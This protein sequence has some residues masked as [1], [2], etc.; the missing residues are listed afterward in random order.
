MNEALYK[1]R[2]YLPTPT[3]T[4]RRVYEPTLTT[5]NKI[6]QG[7]RQ[8]A[9]VS[10]KGSLLQSLTAP[11]VRGPLLSNNEMAQLRL[12][13]LHQLIKI[14]DSNNIIKIKT[15]TKITDLTGR[16]WWLTL[17]TNSLTLQK[18]TEKHRYYQLKKQYPR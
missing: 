1:K 7:N 6:I 3:A 18:A 16:K 4:G 5:Y 13:L 8:S 10:Q 17:Y 11:Y 2:Q 12:C 15:V 9:H 14:R